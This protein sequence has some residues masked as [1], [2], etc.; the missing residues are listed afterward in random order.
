MRWRVRRTAIVCVDDEEMVLTSLKRQLRHHFGSEYQ[1]EVAADGIEALEI[2]EDLAND[3]IA[4]SVIISDYIMPVMRGDELLKRVH[5]RE[6]NAITILLTGHANTEGVTNAVNYAN[7]YRYIAKPWEQ[8]DLILT[9]TE[10]LRSYAQRKQL[11]EHVEALQV[12]N[13]KLEHLNGSLEL[14]VAAR[15][16]ELQEAYLTLK[17]LHNRME[18]DLAFARQIQ[19]GLLPYPEVTWKML[20]IACYTAPAQE[21]GGDFY[22]Y[23]EINESRFALMIGDIS[24]KGVSAALLMAVSMT[25]LDTSLHQTLLPTERMVWLD[26]A[27]AHYAITHRQ[28]CALCYG[29]FELC[30]DGSLQSTLVNAGG[31]AP[32]IR[33]QNREL[34]W[35]QI[36]GFALGQGLGTMSEYEHMTVSL[37]K[38]DMV[39]LVSDGVVE[40]KNR[41]NEM[42]GFERLEEA[43]INSDPRSASDMVYHLVMEIKQFVDTCDPVDDITIVVALVS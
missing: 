5:M 14:L 31:I 18:G 28:N 40:A 2:I 23:Q 39:I 26:Q 33:R 12:S 22:R 36:G 21:L 27:I 3:G 9:V 6:P 43:L 42:F 38:G 37:F 19:Q 24:G 11:A 35:H 10:A 4:L 7:L 15:T 17:T 1:I 20:D 29:E 41:Y 32:F 16:A 30:A 34:E 13:R 25:L 8:T